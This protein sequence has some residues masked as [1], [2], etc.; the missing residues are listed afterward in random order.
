VK[1]KERPYETALLARYAPTEE[2]R[3]DDIEGKFIST[4]SVKEP[5]GVRREETEKTVNAVHTEDVK[6]LRV[7]LLLRRHI[8]L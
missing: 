3:C 4:T 8:H 7:A 2:P 1:F 5:S 6:G